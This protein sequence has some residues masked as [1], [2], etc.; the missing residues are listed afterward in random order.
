MD[1]PPVRH[2]TSEK[3]WGGGGFGGPMM[4]CR[5]RLLYRRSSSRVPVP[6]FRTLLCRNRSKGRL[7]TYPEHDGIT[8]NSF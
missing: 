1:A 7:E 6:C 4:N 2:R 3:P 8:S 5:A